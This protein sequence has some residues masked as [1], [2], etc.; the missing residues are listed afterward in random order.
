MASNV[1]RV[2][3]IPVSLFPAMTESLSVFLEE[4]QSYRHSYS[5]GGIKLPLCARTQTHTHRYKSAVYVTSDVNVERSRLYF[6]TQ[7]EIQRKSAVMTQTSP[8]IGGF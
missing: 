7:M 6:K 2:L 1:C 4:P 3:V 8:G 5:L